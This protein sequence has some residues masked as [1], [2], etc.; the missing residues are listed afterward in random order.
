[1]GSIKMKG[2]ILN[3]CAVID[4][5]MTHILKLYFISALFFAGPGKKLDS[6]VMG[7]G[8]L[9]APSK[10]WIWRKSYLICT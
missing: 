3:D 10:Q 1:M 2:A 8:I 6:G 4:V 5:D 9:R 7:G